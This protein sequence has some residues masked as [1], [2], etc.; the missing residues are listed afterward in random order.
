MDYMINYSYISHQVIYWDQTY[1]AN[2]LDLI[3]LY[4]VE[5]EGNFWESKYYVSMNIKSQFC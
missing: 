2:K 4:L 3:C 5:D 1:F